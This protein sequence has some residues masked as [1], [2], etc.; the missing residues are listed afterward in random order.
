MTARRAGTSQL[1]FVRAIYHAYRKQHLLPLF[2]WRIVVMVATFVKP[3]LVR[4]LL[5]HLSASGDTAGS[6]GLAGAGMLTLPRARARSG[7]CA[8]KCSAGPLQR[9]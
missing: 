7:R 1:T 6:I 3:F 2:L 8:D 9:C 5:D 4:A